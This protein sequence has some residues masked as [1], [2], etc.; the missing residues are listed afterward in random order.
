MNGLLTILTLVAFTLMPLPTQSSE[1]DK[2]NIVIDN[3]IAHEGGWSDHKSD[4]GGKT[5]FGITLATAQRY[6]GSKFSAEQ[7]RSISQNEAKQFYKQYVFYANKINEM[8]EQIWDIL[9]DMHVN[10][11]S[12]NANKLLQKA[13][14]RLGQKLE[15]DGVIG[16][17]TKTAVAQVEPRL[18]REA[19]ITQRMAFYAAIIKAKPDQKVFLAGWINRCAQ[20]VNDPKLCK[21]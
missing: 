18:L 6:L 10:H 4:A 21:I 15:V 5:K 7:L 13:L 12:V 14:A 17:G 11:G 9:F 2:I 16:S 3:T 1:F 8:P 19:L 20:F